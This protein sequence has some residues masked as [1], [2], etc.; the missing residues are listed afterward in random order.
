MQA[1]KLEEAQKEW[2]AAEKHLKTTMFKWSQDHLQAGPCYDRAALA[3][4]V[5]VVTCSA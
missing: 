5:E 4:K 2:A 3:F 1:K